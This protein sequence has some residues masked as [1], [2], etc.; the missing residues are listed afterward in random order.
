MEFHPN[1]SLRSINDLYYDGK[2]G[3]NRANV[4]NPTTLR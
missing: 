3:L 2:I 1:L 4:L